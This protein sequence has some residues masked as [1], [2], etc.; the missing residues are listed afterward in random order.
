MNLSMRTACFHTH[1]GLT[2]PTEYS[3]IPPAIHFLYIVTR[4]Q[5]LGLG[6]SYLNPILP[7]FIILYPNLVPW[8]F[9]NISCIFIHLH[10]ILFWLFLLPEQP[11]HCQ[12]MSIHSQGPTQILSPTVLH[13]FHRQHNK[14]PQHYAELFIFSSQVICY[15]PFS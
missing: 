2:S 15:L 7:V 1:F 14:L 11:S 5:P 3:P 4:T 9:P 6:L 12:T 8:S 13:C 10:F